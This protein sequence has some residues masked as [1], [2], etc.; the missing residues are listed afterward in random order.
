ME[1]RPGLHQW[2]A[3]TAGDRTG[4]GF[5]KTG[6]VSSLKAHPMGL[7]LPP[8]QPPL[9]ASLWPPFC[10][11]LVICSPTARTQA[12]SVLRPF[13]QVMGY[14]EEENPQRAVT[15]PCLKSANVTLFGKR[16]SADIIKDLVMKR[17]S[18]VMGS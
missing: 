7:S 10:H 8:P 17:L 3:L 12:Y 2:G 9:P 14:I 6:P 13:E 1:L 5:L 4:L 16:V 15:S 18:W 11:L